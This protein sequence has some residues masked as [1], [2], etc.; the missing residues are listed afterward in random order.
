MYT[1]IHEVFFATFPSKLHLWLARL[2]DCSRYI[3][4]DKPVQWNQAA[5]QRLKNT[6]NVV[7]RAV[8]FWL[9]NLLLGF[10]IEFDVDT[11]KAYNEAE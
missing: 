8:D 1:N 3:R 4:S 5:V 7:S 6:N 2:A 9:A 11:V 10:I